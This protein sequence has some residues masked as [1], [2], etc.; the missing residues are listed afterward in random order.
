MMQFIPVIF[1]TLICYFEQTSFGKMINF[2]HLKT[3]KPRHL[4]DKFFIGFCC[5]KNENDSRLHLRIMLLSIIK[6]FK[7]DYHNIKYGLK[8][9]RN[10]AQPMIRLDKFQSTQWISIEAE[11][12]ELK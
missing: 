10:L 1:L 3:R 7:I 9:S 8:I 5:K 12:K 11:S 6:T 4:G 2:C